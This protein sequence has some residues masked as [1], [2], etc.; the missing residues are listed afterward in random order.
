[1]RTSALNVAALS[2]TKKWTYLP[3]GAWAKYVPTTAASTFTRNEAAARIV[4]RRKDRLKRHFRSVGPRSTLTYCQSISQHQEYLRKTRIVKRGERVKNHGA[5]V[6]LTLCSQDSR[7]KTDPLRQRPG[8]IVSKCASAA[9]QR[10][11]SE[12]RLETPWL[13]IK[14]CPPEQRVTTYRSRDALRERRPSQF[15]S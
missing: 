9:A 5:F 4:G 12:I 3:N 15:P 7:L 13:R 2:H 11:A 8:V 14:I 1:V 10:Y 6:R